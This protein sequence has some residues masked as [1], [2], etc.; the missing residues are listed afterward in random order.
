M[1]CIDFV[2]ESFNAY[3]DANPD[4]KILVTLHSANGHSPQ[5]C[6]CSNEVEAEDFVGSMCFA[7]NPKGQCFWTYNIVDNPEIACGGII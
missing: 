6:V 7:V 2:R 3:I 1:R 5:Q 4:A